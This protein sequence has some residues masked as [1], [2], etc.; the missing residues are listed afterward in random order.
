MAELKAAGRALTAKQA[1]DRPGTTRAL[2]L[3][4]GGD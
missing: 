2:G 1:R 4:A 3:R